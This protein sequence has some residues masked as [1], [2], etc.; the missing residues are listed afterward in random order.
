MGA[1]Y[2]HNRATRLDKVAHPPP[3]WHSAL[4]QLDD[5]TSWWM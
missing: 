3:G 2:K 4:V 1:E 5:L